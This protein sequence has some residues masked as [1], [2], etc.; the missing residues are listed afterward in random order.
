MADDCKI[1]KVELDLGGVKVE[2]SP[3]QAKKLHS[4]LDDLFGKSYIYSYP[5]PYTMSV[6][7]PYRW[8]YP[9]TAYYGT[10]MGSAKYAGDSG[11]LTLS[12]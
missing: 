7:Y 4:L 9:G 1:S 3:E 6:F 8:G 5:V 2:L 12:V 10:C 11:S